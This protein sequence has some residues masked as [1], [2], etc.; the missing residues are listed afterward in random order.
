MAIHANKGIMGG[1]SESKP[2]ENFS[3]WILDRDEYD[4]LLKYKSN[5]PKLRQEIK[6]LGDEL[7][8]TD[9]ERKKAVKAANKN[10]DA[11]QELKEYFDKHKEDMVK[12]RDNEKHIEDVLRIC[13]ERA[14]KERKIKDKKHDSGY[15]LI[16]SEEYYD[17]YGKN[18]GVWVWKTVIQTPF[19]AEID[20]KTFLNLWNVDE[21]KKQFFNRTHIGTGREMGLNDIRAAKEGKECF[22][23]RTDFKK[24]FKSGFW[25]VTLYNTSEVV[26]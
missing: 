1:Y 13:R 4:A 22:F 11:F 26:A 9:E 21:E 2:G 16:S 17:R 23:Y 5:E 18:N 14:N 19:F 10:Y 20:M 15:V 25:E 3:Y 8:D 6:R 7:Y 12:S 24:N